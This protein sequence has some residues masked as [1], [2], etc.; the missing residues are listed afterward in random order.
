VLRQ[1]RHAVGLALS[2]PGGA[3][4][5]VLALTLASLGL[6][7]G[8]QQAEPPARPPT[9]TSA[10]PPSFVGSEK[11]ASC[12][13]K[14]TEAFRGSDHARAMQPA[15]DQ[16]VLG[17]FDEART[18]Q[19]GVTSTFLRRDGKFLVRTD[20][21]DGKPGDFEI[22]YTFGVDPLQQYLV[23]FPDGRLQALGLAWDTRPRA[24]GGQRW[25]HLYPGQT[26]RA[27]DPL[28]WTGREQTWNFQCAECHSTDLRK[29][30]DLATNRYATTWAELTVSCEECHGPGSGHVA[31]AEARPAG[32][33]GGRGGATGLVVRLG[34]GDGT[35]AIKDPQRGI[36]EWTGPQR[37]SAELD[38]CARCHARR[39]PIVDP[40]P[41]GRPFLDT[42]VPALLESRLYHADGQILGEVYEWGSFVQSRMQRAG[43]TCSDCHEPHR[44]T[45]RAAGN[46]VCAQC[47]LPAKFDAATHHHHRP[48]SAGARCVSCHMAARTY[49]VVDPR[50]DHS[51]RVPRPDLS[52][53]LGTPN[54]CTGCHQDRP[55]RWA[56]DRI[57]AWGG[58][59]QGTPDF[60]RA[61]DA[62]RRGLPDAGPALTALATDERQPGIA[63]ATALSHLPEFWTAGMAAPVESAL[64]DPDALVR[65]AA[66]RATEAMPPEQR[67]RLAAP[68]LR[69][70]VRAVRLAA[71]Q[72]LA[73]A[74]RAPLAE[75]PRADFDR[76][77]AELVQ[78]ELVNADRPEAHVNLSNLYGRLGRP[79]DAESELRTALW[80]DPAF[81]PALVNL[82]DL[83]RTQGRDADGERFLEQALRAAP[84][85]AE[86]LHALA[87][88]RVRQ[89]R[90][91]EAVDLL[92]R[93]T[94]ARPDSPRFAYVYAVALHDTG[95]VAEAITVLEAAHRGRP[96][97]RD[98]LV[99]LATYLAERG[100][101][102]RALQYAEKLQTLD[103]ANAAARSLVET[104]RRR[105]GAG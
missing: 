63:R 81:V 21:P 78:S 75:G 79:G 71:A 26:F 88:L 22:A 104:L 64:R 6:A 34:R 67:G 15:T 77:V 5:A 59:R 35:W 91:P 105:A 19:H 82:A 55:P 14:E 48:E 99:A 30:Y 44:A 33:P 94:R 13:P 24:Q 101:V 45:L 43:V 40:H 17:S 10:A 27:G 36:A 3:R 86:A 41:Y 56:A 42:H 69:D 47:H 70:P 66:L 80:L 84:D 62:A 18:A 49:M 4:R 60:A 38:V 46:A 25:F 74:P 90:L 95:R 51:F 98:T 50:R 87:L 31:W 93:A 72:T 92:R 53:A 85:H 68:L 73:T 20:G 28:H 7:V 102:R 8:C 76:A 54:A 100:D 16:T 57:A 23:R 2:L 32:T 83:L 52:V 11:C 97:D 65:L 89:Q 12:H 29:R 39:R 1:G 103:P 96:A 61:L 58:T 9:A 37:T